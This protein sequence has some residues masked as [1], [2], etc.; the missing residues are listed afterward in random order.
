MRSRDD[1][2]HFL[3]RIGYLL[4]GRRSGA[5]SIGRTS[6]YGSG[7]G[8]RV[9][10]SGCRDQGAGI[11]VQGSGCRDQ[12]SGI[13]VQGAGCRDQ[14]RA[15]AQRTP[16]MSGSLLSSRYFRLPSITSAPA[17]SEHGE[18]LSR[19]YLRL[20][21]FTLSSSESRTWPV[22]SLG[23]SSPVARSRR[24]WKNHP[25]AAIQNPYSPQTGVR[26][27][28]IRRMVKRGHRRPPLQRVAP[29]G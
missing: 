20:L 16:N 28:V 27:L 24:A 2:H 14:R 6:G 19:D 18:L 25:V 8:I 4:A 7:A 21:S 13:R 5:T 26:E 29:P 1:N 3:P 17:N 10:G 23:S 11:R 15:Q 22:S 12:G 9:Q